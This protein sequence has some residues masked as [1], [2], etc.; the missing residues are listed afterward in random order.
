LTP[1]WRRFGVNRFD[2]AS[3]LLPPCREDECIDC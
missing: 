1:T 3:N 2:K